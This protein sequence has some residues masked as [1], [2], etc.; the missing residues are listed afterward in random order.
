M[1]PRQPE[2]SQRIHILIVEDNS[3][4]QEV[5]EAVLSGAGYAVEVASDGLDA[6]RRVRE[7]NYDLAIID[8]QLPEIDGLATAR[9]IRE[10]L[11]E[12]ARPALV[13][14][15][16]WPDHLAHRQG[17]GEIG[18]DAIVVKPLRLPALM[19][20]IEHCLEAAPSKAIRRAAKDA[21]L[22][23]SW[24]DY[25]AEPLL[26]GTPNGQLMP[27]RILLVEDDDLQQR[28]MRSALEQKGYMVE[29]ISDGMHAITMIRERA[30]DLV[31]V[32]YLLPELDGLA[33]ARLIL[34]LMNDDV[35]PRMIA[36]TAAPTQ[37]SGRQA[38]TGSAFDEVVAKS[39]GLPALL[40]TVA[41]HLRSAPNRAT[42]QAAEVVLA[43]IAD[44]QA[45]A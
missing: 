25:D 12:T 23:N 28:I 36:L 2:K 22:Q 38:V 6:V 39:A 40:A 37:L 8:Y 45:S 15:T 17:L 20:A 43:P 9:L 33:A 34:D 16:A 44:G 5:L 21:L 30:Y 10:F 19:S 11:G 14:L 13:A 7:G 42:R 35:R 3:P 27:P 26:R 32:D 41:R 1:S 31:L 18:F 29:T 24:A 4:Q